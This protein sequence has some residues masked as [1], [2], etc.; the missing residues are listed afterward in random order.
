MMTYEG[1]KQNASDYARIMSHHHDQPDSAFIGNPVILPI[2]TV[3]GHVQ[4]ACKRTS[5]IAARLECLADAVL[6]PVPE[7]SSGVKICESDPTLCGDLNTL[8]STISLI[9]QRLNRLCSAITG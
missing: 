4:E 2:T 1:T 5:E 3:R 9:E 6:M 8:L 7:V